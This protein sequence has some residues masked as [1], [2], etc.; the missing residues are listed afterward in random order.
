M[1]LWKTVTAEM[2]N[3]FRVESP[4]LPPTRYIMLLSP[5]T[6]LRAVESAL[7]VPDVQ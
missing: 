4:P 5:L 6:T 2:A 1:N 7:C 3:E